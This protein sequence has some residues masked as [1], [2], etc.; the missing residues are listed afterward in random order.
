MLKVRVHGIKDGLHEIDETA[1]VSTIEDIFPEFIGQIELKGNL[2]KLGKR[3]SF[4][5]TAECQAL[6]LCDISLT[7]YREMIKTDIKISFIADTE[8]YLLQ[9]ENEYNEKDEYAIRDDEE[10]CDLTKEVCE[11]LSLKLPMK[12]IAPNLRDKKF[13]EIY[14]ELAADSENAGKKEEQLDDRWAALKKLKLN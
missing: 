2:R 9:G 8:L 14:P 3:F 5:G 1:D 7:E 12:R 4:S 13:E 11:Q 6:L 10:Y